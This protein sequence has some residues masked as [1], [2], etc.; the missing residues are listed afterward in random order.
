M[1]ETIAVAG[2]PVPTPIVEPIDPSL[3]LFAEIDR[4]VEA[5]PSCGE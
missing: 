3:D 1:A 5:N 4:H 2:R